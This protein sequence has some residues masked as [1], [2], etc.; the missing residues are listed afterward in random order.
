MSPTEQTAV[1][2]RAQRS[3][4]SHC[5]KSRRRPASTAGVTASNKGCGRVLTYRPPIDAVLKCPHDAIGKRPAMIAGRQFL[6]LESIR[7]TYELS[8]SESR[9]RQTHQVI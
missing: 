5:T 2:H 8:K 3:P 6:H 4:C 7:N 9:E 1:D